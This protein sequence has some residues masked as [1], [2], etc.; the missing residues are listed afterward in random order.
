[1]KQQLFI[2]FILLFC[3]SINTS[4][5]I[6]SNSPARP[7]NSNNSYAYGIMPTN[8]PSGGTYGKSTEA[9]NAYE[10][11]KSSFV[12]TCTGK[13]SRV[14]FDDNSSTVSEGIA[15]GMLLAAYAGDKPLFDGLW[16]FYKA[17]V[18]SLGVMHWKYSDCT[19]ASGQNG[20]TDAELDAA[21]ALLVAE[22]Q[23][24]SATSPYEYKSEA[25]SLIGKIRAYEIH[26]TSYHTLNGDA[27]GTT[28]TCRNPSYFAPAYYREYAKNETS[29][30]TFWNNT[31]TATNSFLLSNRNATTGLVSN[32]ADNNATPNGCNGPNEYGFDACRN[33]WRMATDVLWNGSSTAT[34]AYDICN[35]MSN[36]LKGNEANLKGPLAQTASN[37]SVGSY[38]NGSFCTYALAVMGTTSANQ[39]SLNSCYTNVVNLGNTE[40][41]FSR[42]LR[43]LTLFMMTGNYWQPGGGSTPSAPT[44]VS[45]T[46][47]STGSM[48]SILFSKSMSAPT[49]TAYT[50]FTLKING[51]TVSNAFTA[52]A[53]NATNTTIDLTL[54]NAPVPGD[55]ITISYTPG[56]IKSTD[57]A[58]LA[59]F[60]NQ[61]VVNGLAGNSTLLDDCEDGDNTNNL[62]GKWFTYNDNANGGSSTVTPLTSDLSP[63]T[64][65]TGGAN[66]ST[67][68]AK[69]SYTL[70][71]GTLTYDPF[72]GI[73]T[74][75]NSDPLLTADWSTG[76]GLSFYYKGNACILQLVTKEVT[77]AGYYYVTIPASTAAYT[78]MSFNWS[79]FVQPNWAKVVTLNKAAIHKLQWQIQTTTGATGEV[80]LDDIKV[81][82]MMATS[83]TTPTVAITPSAPA[84]CKGSSVSLT[85]SGANSYAWST[86]ASTASVSVSP[87]TTTTYTVTGTAA[88]GTCSAA[89]SVVVTV[90]AVPTANAGANKSVCKGASTSLTATGGG[91][92]AWSTSAS[93][94]SIS[95]TPAVTSTYTVTVTSNGCT[96]TDNA[97]VTVNAVPTANAG[98]D[99]EICKGKFASLSA[100]STG[101]G[102]TFNWSN[103]TATAAN[104]VSPAATT[105]YTVTASIAYTGNTCTGTDAVIVTVN[106]LPT[107]TV[108]ATSPCVGGTLNLSSTTASSYSWSGPLSYTASTQYPIRTSAATTMNGVYYVTVTDSKSCSN[109][110]SVNVTVNPNPTA[111]AGA[112]KSICKGASTSLTATGGGAYAWSTSANTASISVTPAVTSTYTVTVTSSGCTSTDNAVVTV[113]ILPTAAVT[114]ATVCKGGTASVTASGGTMYAW[115]TG[116][117]TASISITPNTTTTYTVTVTNQNGCTDTESTIVYVNALPTAAISGMSTICSGGSTTLTA[118]GGTSYAW[119]TSANTPS[120]TVSPISNTTYT[121]TV[122]SNGCSDSEVI[123]VNVSTSLLASISGMSS[124]CM[125]TST[126]LTASGG[127]TYTWNDNSTSAIRTVSPLVNTTYSVTASSNGCSDSE[128]ITV[129]V[130][131]NPTA[132]AGSDVSVCSG[133]SASLTAL[134][135]EAFSWSTGAQTSI[136]SV[137]PIETSVYVVTVSNGSCTSTD[138]V[139]VTVTSAPVASAGEDVAICKGSSATLSA[140]GGGTY[141]W[142]TNSP[143][144]YISVTPVVTKKYTVTVT[145]NG[146]TNSDAITVTVNALPTANAGNDLTVCEG[147]STTL[148]ATGGTTY[149]WSSGSLIATAEVTPTV[150]TVYT[151]TVTSNACTSTDE[152]VVMVNALPAAPV[153]TEDNSILYSTVA[154][155]NT[156]YET[157]NGVIADAVDSVYAPAASGEYYAVVTANG[158]SSAPSNKIQ[159]VITSD[160]ASQQKTLSVYPNPAQDILY[161]SGAEGK[162]EL[163]LYDMMGKQVLATSINGDNTIDIANLATGMYTLK[164]QQ[165]GTVKHSYL[166]KQ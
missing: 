77:D 12:R 123:S 42:T 21:M 10:A 99:T 63:L 56:T 35:K 43:C 41:Y 106:A 114:S 53:L 58:T 151:V 20:A 65:T 2:L 150:E 98:V 163:S 115:N 113:N 81:E 102:A 96:S 124:I 28:N 3:S 139:Q 87:T 85:A 57:N 162:A 134:G 76:T 154:T 55:V 64:M 144:S 40:A 25:V 72:V 132:D 90:N 8:L 79:S 86:T 148:T 109:T 61:T 17:S 156:W 37:P 15:Y 111:N 131:S 126:S 19:N 129:I 141:K 24:P 29:Q 136:V 137:S 92:Y 158:C 165:H 88:T 33:P 142:S 44:F 166:I 75:A 31:V 147:V 161:I 32:W 95:V 83:C 69:I 93:A 50:N 66:S 153:I 60:S 45:A 119:N 23:W 100:T 145:L 46:T 4:A 146:C 80:W 9:A 101:A 164:I 125:G 68:A 143:A 48:L 6:N 62:G 82:G 104:T 117:T 89:A 121:V 140:T 94:A 133:I 105:T 112:D 5:Q 149:A 11:W 122:T 78:K 38:K 51:T 47:N 7:F 120:I 71:K 130:N 18:N 59:S 159:F 107:P 73:G 127:L 54:A 135:G 108:T 128:Q 118:S 138:A 84:I 91:T 110:S 160:F 30:A 97:V 49:T 116:L 14:L 1:M 152:V 26:P 67:K 74:N 70:N 13:G 157:A 52:I 36:W 103:A 34:T 39:N 27:W 22:E 155:G 16:Q